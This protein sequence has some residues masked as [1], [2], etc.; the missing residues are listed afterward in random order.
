MD[1]GE[2]LHVERTLLAWIRTAATLAAGGLVAAGVAGRYGGDGLAAVPFV[3]TSG[4]GAV[5][6]ARSGVRHRRVQRALREG[7]PPAGIRVDALLAWFGT[8]CAAG[9][10]IA[11]ALTPG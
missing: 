8:L 5:L 7:A 11:F 1:T 4:C 10:A 6:L 9:G 3:L 2:G